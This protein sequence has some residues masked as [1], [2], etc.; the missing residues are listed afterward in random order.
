M[1]SAHLWA[2]LYIVY[3]QNQLRGSGVCDTSLG[4]F[5]R[6]RELPFTGG[7]L[8]KDLDSARLLDFAVTLPSR[9]FF[10]FF[11]FFGACLSKTPVWFRICKI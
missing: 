9:F 6:H 7:Y 10:F 2:L 1:A 11:F 3:L 8:R 4:G 5:Q